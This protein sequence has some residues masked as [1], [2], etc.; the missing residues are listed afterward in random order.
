MINR[1]PFSNRQVIFIINKTSISDLKQSE[2]KFRHSQQAFLCSS[3]AKNY[4]SM[5]GGSEKGGKGKRRKEGNACK[6]TAGFWKPPTHKQRCHAVINK[7][8]KSL[9]F[10]SRS[11][12][13]TTTKWWEWANVDDSGRSMQ[14]FKVKFGN[15]LSSYISNRKECKDEV[16]AQICEKYLSS[17]CIIFVLVRFKIFDHCAHSVNSSKGVK[18][19]LR[20]TP[21]QQIGCWRIVLSPVTKTNGKSWNLGRRGFIYPQYVRR[22]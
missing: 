10:C 1:N 17:F 9:A 8:I 5:N 12:P 18:K 14:A 19:H 20:E 4:R 13:W 16:L 15:L 3:G 21:D 11:E 22:K 6:Q 7:P 2:L